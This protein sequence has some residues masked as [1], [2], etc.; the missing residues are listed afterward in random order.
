ML[1]QPVVLISG[2]GSGIGAVMANTF[3]SAGYRVGIA[4]IDFSS[5]QRVSS[6][7]PD[8]V[9]IKLDVRD[10]ASASAAIDQMI[11]HSG[12]IDV[13]VNNAAV[14]TDTTLEELTVAEW[15]NDI[16]VSLTGAF[17][18]T[19]RALRYM[20]PAGGGC[21][22]NISSVNA[23]GY[24]GNESYSAA[25]AG[26]LSF[27]RSIAVRY[28]PDHIRCNALLPGTIRTPAWDA[29]LAADPT[30][31]DSLNRFYPLGRL[32]EPEDVANAALFLA[33]PSAAWISGVS[34]PV[35]GG[36]TA[37]NRALVDSIVP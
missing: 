33:S 11:D 7:V 1:E 26:L 21:I 16:S 27:T 12:Q 22:V 8:S 35:D 17:L 4:D 5:A 23:L 20:V 31:F 2:A 29:R 37:G 24:F 32:G 28:G 14:C 34:L 9:A 10:E 3:R 30:V 36:L 19:K 13:L 6:G 18:T 15:C 25:K